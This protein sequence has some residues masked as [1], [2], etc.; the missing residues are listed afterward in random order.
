MVY[1]FL[2][3]LSYGL[4]LITVLKDPGYIKKNVSRNKNEDLKYLM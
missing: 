1:A 3:L 4:F 2:I